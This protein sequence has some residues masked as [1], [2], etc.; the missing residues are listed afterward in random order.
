M[1]TSNNKINQNFETHVKQRSV[2]VDN[3]I[4]FGM[5]PCN[6]GLGS[7]GTVIALKGQ[8]PLQSQKT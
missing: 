7:S 6:R 2:R 3:S 1:G 4:A 8:I 5:T